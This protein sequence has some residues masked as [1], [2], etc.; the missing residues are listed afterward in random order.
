MIGFLH[1]GTTPQPRGLCIKK[2]FGAPYKSRRIRSSS[3]EL[4]RLYFL[5]WL[6]SALVNYITRARDL[7]RIQQFSFPIQILQRKRQK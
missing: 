3:G 6:R 5:R 1:E 7:L 2:S 4:A